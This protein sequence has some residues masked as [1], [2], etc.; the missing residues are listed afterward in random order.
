MGLKTFVFFAA[1]YGVFHR[2]SVRLRRN[3]IYTT[4]LKTKKKKK[5]KRVAARVN[6][7]RSRRPWTSGVRCGCSLRRLF[8]GE[9]SYQARQETRLHG[10]LGGP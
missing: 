2:I 6:R 10:N 7:L 5:I 4:K 8:G 9:G 3:L 1:R